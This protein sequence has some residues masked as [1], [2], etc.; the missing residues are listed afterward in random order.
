[1]LKAELGNG[2]SRV[3]TR[4]AIAAFFQIFMAFISFFGGMFF[5]SADSSVNA[6]V[7]VHE[8]PL[9]NFMNKL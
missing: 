1:M 9:F 2:A 5:P 7:R 8:R 3:V 4:V 6:L